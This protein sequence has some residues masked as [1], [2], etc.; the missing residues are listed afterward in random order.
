MIRASLRDL[1][2]ASLR[3]FCWILRV[4]RCRHVVIAYKLQHLTDEACAFRLRCAIPESKL[5]H[6]YNGTI[7]YFIGLGSKVPGEPHWPGLARRPAHV[8][9]T[10]RKVENFATM[11]QHVFQRIR[12]TSPPNSVFHLHTI[13]FRGGRHRIQQRKR[14]SNSLKN[15][16]QKPVLQ[17]TVINLI[18]QHRISG[19]NK[20]LKKLSMCSNTVGKSKEPN[21]VRHDEEGSCDFSES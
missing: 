1:V 20:L 18:K 15:D 3:D 7:L 10:V 14:R 11:E 6:G 21:A 16:E 13:R 9:R 19:I 4:F 8:T 12:I 5:H 2:R 17:G